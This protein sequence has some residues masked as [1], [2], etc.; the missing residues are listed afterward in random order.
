[1][2]INLIIVIGMNIKIISRKTNLEKWLSVDE[3]YNEYSI[4][5]MVRNNIS[6]SN[7]HLVDEGTLE[8]VNSWGKC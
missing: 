2:L 3:T 6:I 5:M 8:V 7:Y 4:S 1:M